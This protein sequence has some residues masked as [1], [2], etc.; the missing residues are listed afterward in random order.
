MGGACNTHGGN[1]KWIQ[2]W[3]ESWGNS[4]VSC[5]LDSFGAG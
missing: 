2:Y 5:G 3:N 1:D 4:L